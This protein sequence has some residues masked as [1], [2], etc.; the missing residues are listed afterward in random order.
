MKKLIA[1]TLVILALYSTVGATYE[2][3]MD[4]MATMIATAVV[5][6]AECGRQAE[7]LRS[8]KIDAE[9][10][11]YS[12]IA[13]DELYLLAKIIYA[14]AGSAWLDDDWK[15]SVGEVALNRVVHERFPNTLSEVIFQPNQ[16]Y[17]SQSRYFAN[18]R[19][20]ERCVVLA[21]RLLEGERVLNDASVVFQANFK[22]GSETHTARYDKHLGWTYFCKI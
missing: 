15:M 2:P 1:T 22:Q 6:D 4:C 10:L 7:Q 9:Q 8:E 11:E 19:P 3:Q 12:K 21:K 13:W 5:G 20:D 18:L 16:Y 17:G 14:E